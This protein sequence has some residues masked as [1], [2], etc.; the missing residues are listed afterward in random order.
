MST[1]QYK[2]V[3]QVD[4]HAKIAGTSADF[5]YSMALDG[6][7]QGTSAN[8]LA[9]VMTGCSI[10]KSFY[11]CRSGRNTFTV[12][13]L[14]VD[15]TITIPAG[16]YKAA[17]FR[18]TVIALLNT[19]SPNGY[20][21]AATFS[22]ITN[23]F[24]FT[25]SAGTPT[26]TM[27]SAVGSGLHDLFGLEQR[28][29]TAVPFT[30]PNSV[31]FSSQT[32]VQVRSN[33]VS[34]ADNILQA[35]YAPEFEPFSTIVY[36]TTDLDARAK[37]LATLNCGA[38]RFYI[39]DE[40]AQPLDLN[41]LAMTLTVMIYRPLDYVLR[42][43]IEMKYQSEIEDSPLDT[44]DATLS[45]MLKLQQRSSAQAVPVLTAAAPAPIN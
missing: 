5:T 28:S 9:I 45:Q 37:P 36:V 42:E 13:E 40:D 3:I 35:V 12:T 33:L 20:V 29:T 30:S 17:N 43:Y 32:T 27:P 18:T 23:K 15:R 7:P 14:G 6:V 38:A 34:G 10:P 4:S 44:I 2:R 31:R 21:Y 24:S 11:N 39:T 25:V 16:N 8:D 26:F 19:P 22:T 41:G 1:Q